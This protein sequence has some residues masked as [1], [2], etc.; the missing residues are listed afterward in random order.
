MTLADFPRTSSIGSGFFFWGIILLPVETESLGVINPNSSEAHSTHS[1]P[2][3]ERWTA[4]M[5]LA[6]RNSN[7]KSRSETA[8]ILFKIIKCHR[9]F[10]NARDQEVCKIQSKNVQQM[11]ANGQKNHHCQALQIDHVGQTDHRNSKTNSKA[12]FENKFLSIWY[13]FA[14]SFCI[15]ASKFIFKPNKKISRQNPMLDKC[16]F[17]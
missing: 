15:L 7:T 4:V 16:N 5:E 6:E 1:S 8:S 3:R 9:L 10:V 12:P 11:N 17:L 2:S 13:M 14:F